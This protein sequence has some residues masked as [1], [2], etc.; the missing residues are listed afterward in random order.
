MAPESVQ[1]PVPF[2]VTPVGL[3]TPGMVRT[4]L[5]AFTLA[6]VAML[7]LAVLPFSAVMIVPLAIPVPVIVELADIP[8][9]DARVSWVLPLAAVAVVIVA[10]EAASTMAPAISPE[11][12]PPRTSVLKPREVAAEV[13]LLVNFSKPVPF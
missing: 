9:T 10:P 5:D 4:V 6:V 12:L 13:T 11:P 7:R 3:I 1:V 2:L 8:S